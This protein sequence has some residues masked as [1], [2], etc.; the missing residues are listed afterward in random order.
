[1]AY[2]LSE[3]LYEKIKILIETSGLPMP[4]PEKRTTATKPRP[5]S[6][7]FFSLDE[8]LYTGQSAA[9]TIG[10]QKWGYAGG[11][12]WYDFVPGGDSTTEIYDV[13]MLCDGVL[14]ADTLVMAAYV[15]DAW[16]F[17]RSTQGCSGGTLLGKTSAA[18]DK[19]S[20]QDITVYSGA[21]GAE[22]VLNRKDSSGVD[23]PVKVSCYNRFADVAAN[24][25]VR[26]TPGGDL[27][28][29]ECG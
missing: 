3:G 8:P 23:Q 2:V 17:I 7:A 20:S 24:K 21:K 26:I 13:F 5:T 22:S 19:G 25:W 4:E 9:A 14:P 12:M 6:M 18:W 10:R 1:M 27:I 29:A 15:G 16:C 28:A 11:N